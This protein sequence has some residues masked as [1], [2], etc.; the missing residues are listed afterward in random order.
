[1]EED[2][3]VG[4]R[5]GRGGGRSTIFHLGKEILDWGG[6]GG[7]HRGCHDMSC[8]VWMAGPSQTVP[9]KTTSA[10]T[11][12]DWQRVLTDYSW[13]QLKQP[14][15]LTEP[16][17]TRGITLYNKEGKSNNTVMS[18]QLST[19]DRQQRNGGGGGGVGGERERDVCDLGGRENKRRENSGGKGS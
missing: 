19:L 1:M 6:G 18:L 15:R 17:I 16:K 13:G 7:G 12:Y 14:C 5:G 8:N 9:V 2:G 3:G 4:A 11:S 10:L